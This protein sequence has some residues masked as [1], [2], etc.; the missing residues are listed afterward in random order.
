MAL[1]VGV[2]YVLKERNARVFNTRQRT[3]DQVVRQIIQDIHS[4]ASH[5]IKQTSRLFF[6]FLSLMIGV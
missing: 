3:T 1:A 4:I 2:Y 6:K 5:C